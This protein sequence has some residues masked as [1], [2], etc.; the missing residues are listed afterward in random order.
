[1]QFAHQGVPIALG[2]DWSA[3]GSYNLLR[4]LACAGSYN[5]NNLG[6]VFKPY[7]LYRMVTE[8]AAALTASDDK[9]GSLKV[10]LFGDVT[11]WAGKPDPYESVVKAAVQDVALVLRGG[12]ALYGEPEAV[13]ALSP[14]GGAGCELVSQGGANDVCGAV[15]KV[16]AQREFGKTVATLQ[17]SIAGVPGGAYPLFFCSAAQAG[18][19]SCVPARPGEFTGVPSAADADG[20]GIPNA[21]DLCPTI[22][23]PTRPLDGGAQADGDGDGLG[24][25]CD[26]CP[27]KAGSLDCPLVSSDI[28][29]DGVPEPAD[30]CPDVPNA[31]QEDAD[32]DQKGDP[33]DACPSTSN[34]GSAPC[35]GQFTITQV[36]GLPLNT[37]VVIKAVAVSA[38][39][40]TG[41]TRGFWVQ[42]AAAGLFAFTGAVS[43]TVVPGDVV[44]LASTVTEFSG[45]KQ[46]ANPFVTKVGSGPAP[47][48]V[49]VSPASIA[50]GGADVNKYMSMLVR[51]ANVS[52]INQN[53]DEPPGDFDEFA[54][55]GNL[56]VD[57]FIFDFDNASFPVGTAFSQITGPLHF[58]F[59]N[60]KILPRTAAD[61]AP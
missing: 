44:D 57:D 7:H 3:S 41:S 33:C 18:E 53:P 27:F 49:V 8:D 20:D 31:G 45:L 52:V 12:T 28:D 9:I 26:P 46:L 40:T 37:A 47:A 10:G 35:P 30:N 61:L 51:V 39:D 5:Q 55:T 23:S 1:V 29:A 25:A 6:G 59:A 48:P 15:R 36:K 56:R 54:V 4:E 17:T 16:C 19:P 2:T 32:G 50:T 60:S 14:G 24:D 21:T 42:D 34:P 11:V 13:D 38:V 43:P 22:F 58:S